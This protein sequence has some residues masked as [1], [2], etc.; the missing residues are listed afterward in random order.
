MIWTQR[1]NIKADMADSISVNNKE[2]EYTVKPKKG[3][4]WSDGQGLIGGRCNFY[5]EV[6]GESRSWSEISGWKFINSRVS[7]DSVKLICRRHIRS[8]PA[9]HRQLTSE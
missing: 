5:V 8:H 4:K 1:G 2:T 3:L 6:I 9:S 7:D